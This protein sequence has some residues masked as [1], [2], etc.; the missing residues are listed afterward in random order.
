VDFAV[1][2]QEYNEALAITPRAAGFHAETLAADALAAHQDNTID[3]IANL[4]IATAE[5][6]RAVANL[7]DTNATLTKELAVSNGKLVL[8]LT[9]VNSLTKQLAA[10]RVVP[11]PRSPTAGPPERK[12]YCWTCGYRC[13]HSSWLC[14][15]PAFGHQTR[16]KAADI[17]NGS[18]KNKP[19]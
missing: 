5:D 3:A 4:A 8:A 6:G 16:A 10:L 7:T 9:V 13:E 19:K 2:Y 11:S 15:T 1:A 12:H 17:M 18:T 14:P